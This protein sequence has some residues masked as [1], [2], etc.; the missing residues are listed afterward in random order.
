MGCDINTEIEKSQPGMGWTDELVFTPA[1]FYSLADGASL[2][3]ATTGI[4]RA[5]D[6]SVYVTLH[7]G[8]SVDQTGGF[9]ASIPVPGWFF[10]GE[11]Q[12]RPQVGIEFAARKVDLTG[13]ATDNAD[14]SLKAELFVKGLADD[15][16]T[17]LGSFT[18]VLP[19]KTAANAP[20]TMLR[21]SDEVL[22]STSA[23]NLAKIVPGAIFVLRLT[24]NEAVGTNLA[25]R[26][27]HVRIQVRRDIK[28]QEPYILT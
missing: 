24:V 10:R 16:L 25:V 6:N 12:R 11:F 2:T 27:Q 14:L 9:E 4:G 19:A 28:V 23:A 21:Y 18:Q 17:S 8:G 5:R 1:D 15:T 22:Q 26:I 7:A 13:S 3:T 20:G